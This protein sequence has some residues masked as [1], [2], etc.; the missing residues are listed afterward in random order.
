MDRVLQMTPLDTTV[1]KNPDDVADDK[2]LRRSK[3]APFN[4]RKPGNRTKERVVVKEVSGGDDIE[5][6]VFATPD[7]KDVEWWSTRDFFE[8]LF[9]CHL[10]AGEQ[11]TGNI[12]WRI[13]GDLGVL[14]QWDRLT[15][16]QPDQRSVHSLV[17][18]TLGADRMLGWS[19]QSVINVQS[20]FLATTPVV[21]EVQ[22]VPFSR[23]DSVLTLPSVG[24]MPANENKVI[25]IS[26]QDEA[27]DVQIQT[28]DSDVVDQV[29]VRGPWEI[30]VGT[31]RFESEWE[32]IWDPDLEEPYAIAY[33]DK[34]GWAG[35]EQY[36]RAEWNAFFREAPKYDEVYRNYGFKPKWDGTCDADPLFAENE[37]ETYVPYIGNIIV[38]PGLPL[39]RGVDYEGAA[40]EVDESKGRRLLPILAYIERPD[41]PG[42][43]T[44]L[45][46]AHSVY[47]APPIRN[48]NKLDYDVSVIANNETEPGFEI[49]VSG[50]PQ[51]ALEPQF[52]PND[53]DPETINPDIWGKYDTRTMLITAA[54]QGDRRPEYRIPDSVTGDLVRQRI[55]TLDHPGL[56]LVHIASSTV[57]AV[58]EDGGTLHS[59]GGILRDPMAEL[60]SLAR[61]AEKSLLAASQDSQH[62]HRSH[63]RRHQHRQS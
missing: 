45:Q 55:I 23:L 19:V 14:P 29:I 40:D 44:T 1:F 58:D 10:T 62:P 12:P 57:V 4:P 60:E 28:D 39:F 3:A 31:F 13:A 25:W 59:D 26:D 53:G 17:N 36:E 63:H 8:Y 37:G 56:Q 18:E 6:Y 52:Q 30:G 5:S 9:V 50:A 27:T 20:N 32:G 24:T 51:H 61:I 42:E 16:N 41:S 35:L 49:Q 54:V 21:E 47:G 48:P 11:G 2:V 15:I 22:I 46:N 33:S 7:D 38:L 43:Y 34:P